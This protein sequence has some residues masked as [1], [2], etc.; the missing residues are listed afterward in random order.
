MHEKITKLIGEKF[1]FRG[2]VW[3]MVEV[4][5]SDDA[6]VITPEKKL[7]TQ[8]R[9]QADQYG[10]AHRRCPECVTLEL[11]NRE[12]NGYSESVMELL[13]GHFTKSSNPE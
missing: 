4:L 8:G 1:I 7:H 12:G 10:Q 5:R 2:Q 6:V 3:I 9:I 13:S 11:S